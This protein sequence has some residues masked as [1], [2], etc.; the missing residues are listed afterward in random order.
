MLNCRSEG[1]RIRWT[2]TLGEERLE[3]EFW[4]LRGSVCAGASKLRIWKVG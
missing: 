2:R 3:S 1:S 4:I